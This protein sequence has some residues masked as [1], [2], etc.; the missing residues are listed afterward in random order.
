MKFREIFRFEFMYQA[1]RI[2]TWLY[3]AVLFV[4]AYLLIRRGFLNDARDGGALVNS[5]YVIAFVT[6]ICNV[7]WLLMATAV[8][9]DSAARDAQT[10]MH[11]LLYTTP[12]SK[13][14]YLGARFLAALALNALILLMVPAGILLALFVPR[15]EPE[16]LGPSQSA[17]L[18]SA[19][20]FIAL[21]TACTATAIQF[22]LAASTGRWV[23][24]YLGGVL[25][26]VMS[27][28]AGFM[29]N[30]LHLWTL[31]ALLEPTHFFVIGLLSR[32]WTPIDKNTRLI[33]L[34]APML[35]NALL[36]VSI[37]L[38]VLIFTHLRFRLGHPGAK[39]GRGAR[40]DGV[41]HSSPRTGAAPV[42]VV[43][44]DNVARA[45]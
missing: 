8:A 20:I 34:E 29:A 15:V 24:S 19:Y 9:G 5:P 44:V 10:R 41:A 14:D 31:G 30:V 27:L 7:L 23:T 26:V 21:P 3:F 2:G 12:I 13:A 45:R 1:R 6:G 35:A 39:L 17:A 25:L 11:P 36:W 28:G 40:R 32:E 42:P 16:V 37:A 4:V 43:P 33:G 22:S 18:I 38:G